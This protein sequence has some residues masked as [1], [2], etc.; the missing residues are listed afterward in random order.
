MTTTLALFGGA[1]VSLALVVGGAFGATLAVRQWLHRPTA[2]T[3]NDPTI[4]AYLQGTPTP[5]LR[6]WRTTHS[7]WVRL[8]DRT[9]LARIQQDN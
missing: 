3:L 1:L 4:T 2:K 6:E 8:I 5:T 9:L 7:E